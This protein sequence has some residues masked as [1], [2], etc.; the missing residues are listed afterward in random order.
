MEKM[1]GRPSQWAVGPL[2]QGG[3]I[4]PR[5]ED[6]GTSTL[7]VRYFEYIGPFIVRVGGEQGLLLFPE[8]SDD[9]GLGSRGPQPCSDGAMLWYR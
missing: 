3:E 8:H 9:F 5:N 7:L 2:L 6:Y 4:P 1:C